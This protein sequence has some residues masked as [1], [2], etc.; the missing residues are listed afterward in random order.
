MNIAARVLRTI[1]WGLPIAW[2]LLRAIDPSGP[3]GRSITSAEL[4]DILG[5]VGVTIT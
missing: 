4:K 3:G 5:K 2:A 1:T